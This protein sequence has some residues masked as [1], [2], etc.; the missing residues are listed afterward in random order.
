MILED[1]VRIEGGFVD[2]VAKIAWLEGAIETELALASDLLALLPPRKQG[3]TRTVLT[4]TECTPT[5]ARYRCDR[6]P[7]ELPAYRMQVTG[8]PGSCLVLSPDVEAWWPANDSEW[9]LGGG[10]TATIDGDGVTIHFPAFGGA[11]TQFHRAEFDEHR[12]YVVGRAITSERKAVSGTA[13][14]ALG[15]NRQVTGRLAAPL[16]GRILL[17]PAGQPLAVVPALASAE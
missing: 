1:R 7:R 9:H 12:S 10:G 8:L 14:P 17:N 2:G 13:V 3:R 6:G 11:L 4:I 15:I 16:A 5:F